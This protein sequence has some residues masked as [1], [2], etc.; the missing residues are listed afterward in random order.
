M[1]PSSQHVQEL[2]MRG[3]YLDHFI[4]LIGKKQCLLYIYSYPHLF[5]HVRMDYLL[6]QKPNSP[7]K[8]LG[9]NF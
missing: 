9:F 3:F 2:E 1:T 4:E 7:E 8:M 6:T 5:I